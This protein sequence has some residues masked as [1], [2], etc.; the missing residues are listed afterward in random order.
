M[1]VA[2]EQQDKHCTRERTLNIFG[3]LK[4]RYKNRL[5]KVNISVQCTVLQIRR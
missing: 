3:L 2:E 5:M 4:E 1:A